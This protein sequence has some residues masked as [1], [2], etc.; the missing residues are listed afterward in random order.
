MALPHENDV[1]A[2]AREET[3]EDVLISDDLIETQRQ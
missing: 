2:F 1:P 3:W